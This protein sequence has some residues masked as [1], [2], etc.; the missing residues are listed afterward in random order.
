MSE[1]TI[2]VLFI[3]LGNIC[4]SPLAEALFRKTVVDEGL[5]SRFRIDSAGTSGYHDGEPPD[6]RTTDTARRRGVEVAGR[7][8][9]VTGADIETFDLV[10]MDAENLRNVERLVAGNGATPRAVRLR[11]FDPEA[12]GD[13]DVPDPYFGG[14]RGF[15]EV[16]EMVERA[17]RGLLEHIR[18]EHG[19]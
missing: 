5:E 19:L 6:A 15:E 13:L 12:E 11:E 18:R 17:A 16:H 3:C 1:D 14:P 8:R 7:S 9:R 10:V 4:R 2:G